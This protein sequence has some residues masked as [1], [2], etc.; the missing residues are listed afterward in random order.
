MA[1][2]YQRIKKQ[3]GVYSFYVQS[4]EEAAFQI[5]SSEQAHV[6]GL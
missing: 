5:E 6:S 3:D 4:V 1:V 2:V